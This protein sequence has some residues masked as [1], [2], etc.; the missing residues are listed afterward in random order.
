[1]SWRL[2]ASSTAA[3]AG[4]ESGQFVGMKIKA[5]ACFAAVSLALSGVVL[6]E[7]RPAVPHVT[8][9]GT[10]TTEAV[11]DELRWNL[12]VE[13]RGGD[14][15]RVADEHGGLVAAVLRF[16]RESGVAEKHVQTAHMQLNEHR[17]M[18][19]GTWTR[20]GYLAQTQVAFR[21]RNPAAYRAL[22]LG[23]SR[24]PGVSIGGVHWEIADRTQVQQ[25]TRAEALAA[26]KSKAADMAGALGARLAEPIVIEEILLDGWPQPMAMNRMAMA[27]EGAGGEE[28][29]APGTIPVRVRVKVTF[30]IVTD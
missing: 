21:T 10:A 7:T 1:M 15:A 6:A 3:C 26:A 12:S 30:R 14:V 28:P 5:A 25:G 17:E 18:V 8:V 2:D 24:L 13:N 22:W 19:G 23:L 16:L 27:A 11:P 29:L 20:Q 9:F 4:A